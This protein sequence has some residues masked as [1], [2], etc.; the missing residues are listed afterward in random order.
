MIKLFPTVCQGTVLKSPAMPTR[1]R[2]GDKAFSWL[3]REVIDKQERGTAMHSVSPEL[4]PE[5]VMN[6][7]FDLVQTLTGL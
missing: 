5:T 1:S 3:G 6:P 4:E 2:D 7:L